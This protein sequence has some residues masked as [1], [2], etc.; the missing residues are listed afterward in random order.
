MNQPTNTDS[1]D[2]LENPFQRLDRYGILGEEPQPILQQ[3]K[4]LF[5]TIFVVPLKLLGTASLILSF[6]IAIKISILFPRD[7]RS[8]IVAFLGK[9]HCRACLF[10]LGFVSVRWVKVPLHAVPYES[11]SLEGVHKG[12]RRVSI[13]SN[14]TSWIDILIHM[15]HSFPAFV[16]RDATKRTPLIGTIR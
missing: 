10:C 7:R 12:Q 9:L 5:W 1:S 15:S 4:L 16:A 13:V 11:P 3:I 8:D 2:I 6:Y 14:H